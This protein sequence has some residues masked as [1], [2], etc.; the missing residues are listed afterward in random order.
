MKNQKIKKLMLSSVLSIALI[1]T[2]TNMVKAHGEASRRVEVWPG[3]ARLFAADNSGAEVVVIDL[4][5][6]KVT[7]RITVPPKVMAMGR[8]EDGAYVVTTRGRD[9]DRDFVTVIS[10]GV[11]AD[12][13]HRP[14]VAKTLLIGK[15]MGGIH[16]DHVDTLWGKPFLVSDEEARLFVFDQK[17]FAP[18][19]AFAPEVISLNIPDH[20]D[21]TKLGQDV[22]ACSLRRGIVRLIDQQG[23]D[24]VTFPCTR[25]HGN[26]ADPETSRAFFAC[27]EGVLAVEQQKEKARIAY[28][29]SERIGHFMDGDGVLIGSSEK[30]QNL[31]L[32]DPK[33]LTL[34]PVPLGS[35]L[36]ARTMSADKKHIFVL[37]QNGNLEVR[38][39]HTG[40][41]IRS[42]IVSTPF[43]A[44][45]EDVTG[46]LMPSIAA[47]EN[48][49]YVSLPQSGI[50]AEVEW[51]EGK[52]LRSLTIG[53]APSRLVLIEGKGQAKVK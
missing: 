47:W 46:A 20:Y 35:M 48:R 52:L 2:V 49:A 23:K 53:G 34:K 39:G 33:N 38:N 31:Q 25:F 32:L 43:P 6:G 7:A 3:G 14:Y 13:M 10:S 41:L 37:L 19:A 29:T 36:M 16:A 27:A 40:D 8:T 15:G 24:V 30:V 9:T 11:E 4:P 28:P 12:G 5:D 1:L 17:A 21:F 50:I 22:W 26:A 18:E 44:M 42:I 45:D 51:L